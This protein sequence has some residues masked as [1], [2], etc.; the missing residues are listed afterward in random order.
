MQ[1]NMN[2][3]SENTTRKMIFLVDD[4]MTNL[5][6][7]Q[8]IIVE[9]YDIFTFNSAARL[10][11]ALEK[12]IP[13]LILLDIEMP[14]MNGYEALKIIKDDIRLKAVPVIFLTARYESES[15]L[16]GLSLGAADYITKPF[17][18]SL[19][20][21]RIEMHLLV[22]EQ[23]KE[24]RIYNNHLHEMVDR[25]TKSVIELQN[26]L[27][28]TMAELVECKDGAT[29]WHIERTQSYLK[30]LLDALIHR[31]LYTEEVSARNTELI[32]Q[33]AQLHD[34]GKIAI[35]DKILQKSGALNEEEREKI[36]KHPVFG[37]RIIERIKQ[38]MTDHT[39]LEYARI[40]AVTH[41]ERWDGKGYPNG[42]KEDEIPL[43]G[44]LMAVADVYDALTSERPYKEPFSHEKAVAII[45]E[46]R[47]TQFNPLVVDLFVSVANEFDEAAK[48]HKAASALQG[49]QRSLFYD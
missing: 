10:L 46:G 26:G 33:S 20:L 40:L 19:L 6:I 3:S 18:P 9:Y 44:R 47:G 27:I 16:V 35:Q 11:K 5:T 28:R 43:L 2:A 24:L 45:L 8:K 4:D 39:F 25:R 22:E 21:K 37:K 34:I 17:A 15:E 29:G 48:K 32:V 36:N 13:D 41:H 23:K 1:I 12:K 42:L 49:T 38:N 14:E 7:A 30:I 31:G